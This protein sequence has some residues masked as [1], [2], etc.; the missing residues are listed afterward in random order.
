MK[1]PDAIYFRNPEDR[2]YCVPLTKFSPDK[3][4]LKL[5]NGRIVKVYEWY[6]GDPERANLIDKSLYLFNP[7][8]LEKIKRFR[9]AVFIME[10]LLPFIDN[11]YMHE[12]LY[13]GEIKTSLCCKPTL[14]KNSQG[15]KTLDQLL[16]SMEAILYDSVKINGEI[17]PIGEA[18]NNEKYNTKLFLLAIKDI[19]PLVYADIRLYNLCY[20]SYDKDSNSSLFTQIFRITSDYFLEEKKNQRILERN[21]LILLL[22]NE[23]FKYKRRFSVDWF[24]LNVLNLVSY[25]DG[26]DLVKLLKEPKII[27]I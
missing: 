6:L 14:K 25:I 12:E 4:K 3:D 21:G 9:S 5:R 17:I 22:V 8:S 11:F 23:D 19:F 13:R 15:F 16:F 18:I 7:K 26:L 2:S 10:R 20:D 24:L 27:T 1:K